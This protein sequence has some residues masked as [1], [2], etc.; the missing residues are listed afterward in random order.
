MPKDQA[1]EKRQ[2]IRLGS[3]ANRCPWSLPG[4]DP[5]S[6]RPEVQRDGADFLAGDPSRIEAGWVQG[7]C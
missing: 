3:Y 5:D 4:K 1:R 2:G 7:L 6:Q